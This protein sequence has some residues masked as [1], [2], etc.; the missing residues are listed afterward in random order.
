MLVSVIMIT[1][2]HSPYIKQAIES[3]LSQNTNFEFELI[4]SNDNSTD[5]TDAVI[6]DT[7][8]NNPNGYKAKYYNNETNLGMMP[9]SVSALNKASGK[10]I[11]SCEGDDYWCDNQK[12]QIQTDF[13]E[14]NPD[15]SICFHNVY[16]LTGTE[17][18]EDNKKKKIPE[19]TTINDLAKNNYIHTPSVIYRNNLFGEL[20]KYFSEAPIGDYFLHM[21]NA[22]HGKIKYIDKIMSVYRIHNTSYWSSKKDAEQ[23]IIMIDFLNKLKT[24]F[25]SDIQKILN[26]QILKIKSKDFS[27][28][29]KLN[30]KIKSLFQ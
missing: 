6:R 5:D 19:I 28:F 29:Q 7:L 8:A 26:K 25:D 11:A 23:R 3:V 24:Y 4:I 12:L 9:N 27:F 22:Q 30:Y 20:P 21:L 10:Y 13:L 17:L 18:K 15:F 14:N 16:L 1:Y 2:N